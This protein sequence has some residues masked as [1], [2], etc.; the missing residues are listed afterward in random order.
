MPLVITSSTSSQPFEKIYLDIVG[1]LTC[2]QSGNKY[3][4]TAQDDLTKYSIA[5]TIPDQEAKTIAKELIQEKIAGELKN[6][7]SV[8]SVTNE[9]EVVNYPTEF[10]NSLDLPGLL[11]H[12]L[13]L[14]IG[15]VIIM[16]RNINQPRLCNGTRLA[17]KKL[18]NN[19][20][21][22]TILKEK[23]KG[24]DVL[25]PRI[26]MIPNDMPFNFKRL[27]CGLHLQCR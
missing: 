3:I 18:L 6:Y 26:P 25:I 10:L 20:I 22:A 15:S 4:L 12:N 5:M 17:V 8:D 1:P 11:P 7:K 24:E 19:V 23:Y 14:K 21:E 9:D 2:S 27:P 16:L 13:Q